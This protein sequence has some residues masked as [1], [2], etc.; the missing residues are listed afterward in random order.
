MPSNKM[1]R[2]SE[3]IKR[4]LNE[5]LQREVKDKKVG[6]IT[7]TA[8]EVTNDLSFCKVYYTVYGPGYSER[9]AAAALDRA[10][11]FIRSELA[12]R[13]STLRK[14]PELIFTIDEST[15]YGNK[16]DTMLAELSRR[17]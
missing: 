2:T 6:F 3:Q 17:D 14:M 8:C 12:K 1:A 7:I 10:K 9:D 4:H 13:M 16:I 5:I 15:K 11:G